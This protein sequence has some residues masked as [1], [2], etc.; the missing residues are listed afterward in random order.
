MRV[1]IIAAMFNDQVT[2]RLCDGA[3]A[4]AVEH[5]VDERSVDVFWVPGAFELPL[6]AQEVV[7]TGVYDAVACVGAVVR[8]ETPHFDFVAGEAARAL[9]EVGRETGVPVGFG[10]ITSDT[11][12]QAEA[13]AGGAV[14]NKGS[15]AMYAALHVAALLRDV[16]VVEAE[17]TS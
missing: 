10:L 6:V 9:M 12:A 5:G 3:L 17:E 14:G 7:S 11:M 15:E 16:V 4:T 8:G 13:R 2:K 1:A